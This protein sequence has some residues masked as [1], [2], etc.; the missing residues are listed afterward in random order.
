MKMDSFQEGD[1]LCGE[2]LSGRGAADKEEVTVNVKL[3]LH[4][5]QAVTVSSRKS[6]M[7]PGCET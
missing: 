2:T 4:W 3:V 5:L 6:M 7:V 1:V